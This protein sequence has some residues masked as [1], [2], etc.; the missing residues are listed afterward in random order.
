MLFWNKTFALTVRALRLDARRQQSH[1]YRFGFCFLI[2]TNLVAVQ[3]AG[4][5]GAPGRQLFEWIIYTNAVLATI[6]V[7]LLFGSAITEEKEERTLAMLRIA[8]VSPLAILMG[9]FLPRLVVLLLVLVVQFPFTLLSITLGG[10]TFDQIAASYSAVAAYLL[11]IA[12]MSLLCSV[13]FRL[14][15]NATGAAVLLIVA[16][17]AIP[18]ILY[19]AGTT[20]AA[21]GDIP[22]FWQEVGNVAVTIAD[23][24]N[25]TNVFVRL[26]VILE[27]G[28]R[29]PILTAQVAVNLI[30]AILSL[31]IA[32]GTFDFFNRDLEGVAVTASPTRPGRR[33]SRSRPW[34]DAIAWK[35]FHHAAGGWRYLRVKVLMYLMLLVGIP[36]STGGWDP[37]AISIETSGVTL[38][39]IFWQFLLPIETTLTIA[40]LVHPEVKGQTLSSL[41]M[42]P[43]TTREMLAAKLRGGL[44]A[45][46]PVLMF[47]AVS[48][49]I[50]PELIPRG[51]RAIADHPGMVT[52][53]GLLAILNV[54][55]FWLL[56][57]SFSLSLNPWVSML[58]AYFL[59]YYGSVIV[60]GSAAGLLAWLISSAWLRDVGFYMI[61]V[62]NGLITASLVWLMFLGIPKQIEEKGSMS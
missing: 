54:L 20:L 27:S 62:A 60:Y 25:S 26:Q 49:F 14:S 36:L 12:A 29:E 33:A 28:S 9:K 53:I 19:L 8:D 35:E 23:R 31:L 10:V 22:P 42:L 34:R 13:P 40:R 37:S 2:L 45:V 47:G 3:Q 16:Y 21:H 6:A 44:L 30:L 7:P 58:A 1:G 38:S 43:I 15:A 50:W 48:L 5:A 39:F 24:L 11:F 4:I 57:V 17:H 59:Q 32:W 46:I 18:W 56:V 52:G 55:L 51:L 61:A 41:L